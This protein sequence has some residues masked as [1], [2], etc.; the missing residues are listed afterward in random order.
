MISYPILDVTKKKKIKD[1]EI[2]VLYLNTFVPETYFRS[3][4]FQYIKQNF[5]LFKT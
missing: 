4:F 3:Q 5:M 2:T 1:C